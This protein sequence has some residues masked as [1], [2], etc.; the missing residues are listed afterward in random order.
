MR[1]AVDFNFLVSPSLLVADVIGPFGRVWELMGCAVKLVAPDGLAPLESL[2]GDGLGG[3]AGSSG[4]EPCQEDEG[5]ERGGSDPL[6]GELAKPVEEC[7]GWSG[8]VIGD[9]LRWVK[10]FQGVMQVWLDACRLL[11]PGEKLWD[12]VTEGKGDLQYAV[13]AVCGIDFVKFLAE[14]ASSDADDGVDAGVE[15]GGFAAEGLDGDGV[16]AD[17]AGLAV[18][19]FGADEGE[20]AD[21]IGGAGDFRVLEDP[22]EF[23]FLSSENG[24][25]RRWGGLGGM[26]S[27]GKL[28][29]TDNR[30]VRWHAHLPR[31]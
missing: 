30:C 5:D 22:G 6:P 25:W 17:F 1:R 23:G 16:F 12:V 8:G 7:C 9:S 29:R 14:S 4:E 13:V 10:G 27:I 26:L 21:E 11:S 24:I 18:K 3:S 19:V 31:S 28:F 15:G 20:D 2:E